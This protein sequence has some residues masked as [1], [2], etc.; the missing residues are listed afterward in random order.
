MHGLDPELGKPGYEDWIRCVHPDDRESVQKSV[1]DAF[2]RQV[3]EYRT[4]YRVV[5]P[6]GEV[7]WLE[8]L[9]KVDYAPGGTP[10]HMSGIMLDIN[11]R[12]RA[13]EELREKEEWLR[14]AVEGSGAAALA[15]G[16]FEG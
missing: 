7:R 6:S 16:Y 8:A 4:E 3:H 12:K 1:F 15:M 13:E 10:V 9:G 5:L 14:L 2:M 11:G